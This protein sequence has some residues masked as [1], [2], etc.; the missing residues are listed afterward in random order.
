MVTYLFH[1]KKQ[2]FWVLG[3]G[4][5][6]LLFRQT[7]IFWVG[8]YL[9]ALE[10]RRSLSLGSQV[11]SNPFSSEMARIRSGGNVYDPVVKDAGLEGICSSVAVQLQEHQLTLEHWISLR[12]QRLLVLRC[13]CGAFTASGYGCLA[14]PVYFGF[15]CPFCSMEWWCRLG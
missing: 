12:Q 11:P 5:V 8:I 9:G 7:N 4:L 3:S 2:S 13:F 6:S 15:L 14:S 1:L 10:V